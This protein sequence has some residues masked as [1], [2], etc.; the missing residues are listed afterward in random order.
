MS[1]VGCQTNVETTKGQPI[2]YGPA[3]HLGLA[4]ARPERVVS[5]QRVKIVTSLDARFSSCTELR[6]IFR[7]LSPDLVALQ[8]SCGNLEGRVH[9]KNFGIF[10]LSILETNQSLF[11]SG[12]RRTKLESCTIAIPLDTYSP[13]HVYRAQGIA[14][15]WPG[16]IGY[17]QCLIDFD[18][19]LPVKAKLATLIIAKEELLKRQAKYANSLLSLER[20]KTTNQLE[21]SP[22]Q[23]QKL[24]QCLD[25]LLKRDSETWQPSK[26]DHLIQLVM[27][28]FS[29]TDAQ[30]M[31]IAKRETRHQAAI[32]LLH[33]CAQNPKQVRTI[34]ELSAEL[35]QSRTSIFKGSK[36]HF[37]RSPL[38][39]QRS[40]RMDRVRQLLLDPARCQMLGLRGVG[41]I[42][43]EL[44][45]TSR[46]H[47]A[48]RYQEMY[49]EQA[50]TTLSRQHQGQ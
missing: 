31:P 5:R 39:V 28:C 4:L 14:M 26:P 12:S 8:L 44:G 18:L 22:E 36:E 48:K 32:E 24:R 6:E 21:V 3:Q 19:K 47:F 30:T 16:F 27:A 45:F 10:K 34:D 49:G 40:I 23:Y 7:P 2:A 33:W 46:S 11:L 13:Q 41:A 43:A 17:N 9:V 42:A 50:Q 35:Y 38:E 15:P 20:F 29:D 1:F 37:D 25:A